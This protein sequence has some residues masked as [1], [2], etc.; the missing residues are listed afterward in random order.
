MCGIAGLI[1]RGKRSDVGTEMTA[2]LQALK[3][4]GPDSTGFAVYGEPVEGDYVLRLK[5]AERNKGLRDA[6]APLL[7]RLGQLP[8]DHPLDAREPVTHVGDPVLVELVAHARRVAPP[9]APYRPR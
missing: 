7:L 5:V 9:R 8:Q 2:M 4:R 6:A 1:H 3:H